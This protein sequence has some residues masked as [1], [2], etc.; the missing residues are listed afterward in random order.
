MKEW[1]KRGMLLLVLLLPLLVLSGCG[2]TVTADVNEYLSFSTSGYD[3]YGALAWNFDRDKLIADLIEKLGYNTERRTGQEMASLLEHAIK[4][5]VKGS[6]DKTEDLA[7]GDVL[8][9]TWEVDDALL[10]ESF[11]LILWHDPKIVDVLN[12]KTGTLVDPFANL[13]VSVTGFNGEGILSYSGD[14]GV[15]GLRYRMEGAREALSNGDSVTFYIDGYTDEKTFLFDTGCAIEVFEKSYTVQDL[16][17][18]IPFDPFDYL[19]LRYE[20]EGPFAELVM[21][22]AELPVEG[23]SFVA[24][25]TGRLSNDQEITVEIVSDT[26]EKDLD[27]FCRRSNYQITKTR[28][29]Y[30]VSGLAEYVREANMLPVDLL[31]DME[32]TLRAFYKDQSDRG[33]RHYAK[34]GDFESFSLNKAYLLYSKDPRPETLLNRLVLVFEVSLKG[35]SKYY[36]VTY[37]ENLFRE[38]DGSVKTDLSAHQEPVH[39]C[40]DQKLIGQINGDILAYGYDE[41]EDAYS[42]LV[43]N[44]Q[45][46][47]RDTEY[48]MDRLQ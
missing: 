10:K 30:T 42:D 44:W 45:F 41:A 29:S 1:L 3:K 33:R 19:T 36:Y 13:Q 34:P 16:I 15:G 25:R 4:A 8:T 46:N 6:W 39:Y 22:T 38:A 23:L 37:Y 2:Q 47:Y 5:V 17:T 20:G 26:G 27:A 24:D 9:Y 11:N 12:L 32:K 40:D 48:S 18:L 21:E 43:R 35:G 28:E 14:P 31:K 7:N